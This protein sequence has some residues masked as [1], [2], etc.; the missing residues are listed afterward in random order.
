MRPIIDES[1]ALVTGASSGIGKAICQQ[2]APKIA[3]L[4]LVARRKERLEA[5]ASELRAAHKGLVVLVEPV[6][7]GDPAAIDAL[8]GR[9][10]P[11]DLLINN[12]GMGDLALFERS[13]W[14]KLENMLMVNI[15]AL[16]QLT[17][18]LID[19]M[20][21]RKRGGI[22]NISSGFGLSFFP[23]AAAYVGSKHFVSG[24]SESLRA[25]LQGTGVTLTQVCPGPV[26]TG[27]EAVAGNP[28]GH[29]IPSFIELSADECAHAAL[30]GFARGKALVIPG[31]WIKIVLF[32]S[33]WTP[34][35]IQRFALR[36]IGPWLRKRP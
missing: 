25:E 22:L 27:F 17:R 26:A 15:N 36:G 33:A 11:V 7:L 3:H 35:F 4:I 18:G 29:Q 9:L 2:L 16:V 24:F 12:A 8:L 28:S 34:R 13:D 10:P 21:E 19:G 31:F 20:L 32:I 6:D 23:G 14:S 30:R 5:L 1:T